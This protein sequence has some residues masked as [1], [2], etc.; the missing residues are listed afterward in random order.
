MLLDAVD[1]EVKDDVLV[2]DRSFCVPLTSCNC[3]YNT[4]YGRVD[5][6]SD[7]PPK[8]YGQSARKIITMKGSEEPPQIETGFFGKRTYVVGK[9]NW[10]F[11]IPIRTLVGP[12]PEIGKIYKIENRE[13]LY[14]NAFLIEM[15]IIKE[16]S[17]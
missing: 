13:Y 8:H 6:V 7:A 9:E 15:T 3:V 5:D 16:W 11:N 1:W 2:L 17:Q 14:G 4:F 12:V 10:T